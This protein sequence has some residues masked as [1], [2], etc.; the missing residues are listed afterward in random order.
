M[1]RRTFTTMFASSAAIL[2]LA[3]TPS[4]AEPKVG[5]PAPAFSAVN[6]DGKTVNL[7]DY[8]G[9]TVVLEWTNDGCPY[10]RK[11][12]GTGNMQALQKK[13]TEQGIVWLT[14]ISSP[15]GEQGF[16]D[17]ARAKSLTAE[18]NAKP[19][20]VLLDPK[21]QVAR[22][23]GATVTPHMYIIKPDGVLAYAGGIDDKPT[24]RAADV[25]DAKNFVDDALAELKAGKSVSNPATRAYGCT[26]KYS[27]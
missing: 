6:T 15:P 16:A 4:Q 9:K 17:A 13:W 23:Y 26:V 2:L 18:R 22:A 27:S 10:V 3:G 25:K 1:D 24:T 12:Y 19:S 7:N 14:V 5:T 21:Q 11:H 8:K 20:S